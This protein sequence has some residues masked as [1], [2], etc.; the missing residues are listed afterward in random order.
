MKKHLLIFSLIAVCLPVRIFLFGS[1]LSY[2]NN[3]AY[4]K[5]AMETGKPT[6][7]D[8]DQ[9]WDTTECPRVAVITSACPDS[10]CGE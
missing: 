2:D 7:I 9:N 1:V 4:Q 3:L 10:A 8:C 6:H 5:L